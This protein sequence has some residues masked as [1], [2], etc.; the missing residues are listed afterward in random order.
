[1]GPRP[2]R[3]RRRRIGL[4]LRCFRR[5]KISCVTIGETLPCGW[6]SLQQ[7]VVDSQQGRRENS[8]SAC[9]AKA[10]TSTASLGR[11]RSAT[12]VGS[13]RRL[14]AAEAEAEDRSSILRIA[15]QDDGAAKG[16]ALIH[17]NSPTNYVLMHLNFHI[18]V[19]SSF[20]AGGKKTHGWPFQRWYRKEAE[21]S[22][23]R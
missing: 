7:R 4:L 3:P 20:L 22:G 2:L 21:A 10:Y 8:Q 12:C 9:D 14:P 18:N 19:Q 11:S 1:M 17:F 6:T 13:R 16:S 23:W 15:R 5:G